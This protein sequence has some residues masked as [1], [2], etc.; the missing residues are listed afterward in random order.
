MY[1]KGNRGP[2]TD[3]MRTLDD[4]ALNLYRSLSRLRN[5]LRDPKLDISPPVNLVLD[6]YSLNRIV[7]TLNDD[8]ARL[9]D[10]DLPRAARRVLP[11][12]QFNA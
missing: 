3:K 12:G 7:S 4:H 2:V 10:A 5:F 1:I 6:L 11:G 8:C 9:V